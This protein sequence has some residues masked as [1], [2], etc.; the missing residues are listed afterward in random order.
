MRTPIR[1]LALLSTLTLVPAAVA[2]AKGGGDGGAHGRAVAEL[3]GKFKWGMS[4]EDCVKVMAEGIRAKYEALLKKE[5]DVYKQDQLRKAARDDEQKIRDSYIKFDGISPGTKEWG[6][7]IIQAEF[8]PRNDESMMT[9]WEKDQRRFLFFW[10]D[11][12][13][14][15]FI[16]FN[17]EH[18]VFAGK[19][20]D[21]FA[22][23][24]Q[25]RYG[26]AQ[27]KFASMRTRDD[28]KLHHLEWPAHGEFQLYAIDQSQF[29]GNYCLVLFNPS[30]A[31]ELD[32]VRGERNT[33][34]ATRNALIESVTQSPKVSGDSNEN[35]VDQ[36]TGK[37][38]QKKAT[39]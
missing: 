31:K 8:A 14:K 27:M 11:K 16:A 23:I 38:P 20:F 1:T 39:P 26:S 10:H 28:M 7:S 36:I 32:K 2:H 13:Y 6:T 4:H 19:S 24:I 22:R 33:K 21:D 17:A 35:V 9:L 12:L 5:Q 34:P 18:P 25:N 3:A 30:V 29:Y 15:Q 37:T